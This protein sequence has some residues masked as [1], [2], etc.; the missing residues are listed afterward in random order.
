[1]EEYTKKRMA[2][3]LLYYAVVF[4]GGFLI[5]CAVTAEEPFFKRHHG[6]GGALLEPLCD[7]LPGLLLSA[8][9]WTFD[10]D[11]IDIEEGFILSLGGDNDATDTFM[12]DGEL[13]LPV[14]D[15][16]ASRLQAD[17][18]ITTGTC[19]GSVQIGSLTS[20]SG[21]VGVQSAPTD[22]YWIII[23]APPNSYY[24]LLLN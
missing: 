8:P 11:S 17:G 22:D 14:Y 20:I 5:G 1:M 4:M 2:L 12:I 21:G 6:G 16:V 7:S 15:A 3:D 23:G 24:G 18:Y 10:A 19:P 9:S 13:L